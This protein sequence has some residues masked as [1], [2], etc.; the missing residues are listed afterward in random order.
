LFRSVKARLL[1]IA[2][3]ALLCGCAPGNALKRDESSLLLER[4][5]VAGVQELFPEQYR[6]LVATFD[7]GEELH[8]AG[9]VSAADGY[10]GFA[11]T[12]AML[13]ESAFAE[14]IKS[15]EAAARRE[16]ELKLRAEAELKAKQ[17]RERAEAEAA[18]ARA[19]EEARAAARRAEAER[20]ETR[21]RAER[22][23]YE[24][25]Q[26]LPLRH[27]VKRGE[28]LPQIAAL[29]EVYGEASLWP[30]LYRANRDQIRDP[31]VLWPGQQL[32]IPRNLDRNDLSEARRFSSE[33]PLR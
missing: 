1:I 4:V 7:K 31:R 6:D 12:K 24:R 33:R 10:Y 5:R 16:A 17:E 22:A 8:L 21:R 3:V 19:A 13:L 29:P 28:T 30:L 15:R 23:K 2:G 25:E 14:E 20:A 26:N 9:D 18:A 11:I 32:K 27:T